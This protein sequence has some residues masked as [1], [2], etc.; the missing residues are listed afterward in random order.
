MHCSCNKYYYQ[1][2]NQILNLYG[3]IVSYFRKIS[4]AEQGHRK[5]QII[6]HGIE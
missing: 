4:Q 6:P 2:L 3:L 5:R 1:E